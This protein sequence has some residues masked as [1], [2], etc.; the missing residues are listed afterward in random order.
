M[1]LDSNSKHDLTV[2]GLFQSSLIRT[3]RTAMIAVAAVVFLFSVINGR[4]NQTRAKAL[5]LN[6]VSSQ[7]KAA[8]M[9]QDILAVT[10]ELDRFI[11]AWDVS[12]PLSAEIEILQDGRL[13]ARAGRAGG[14]M[15]L[16]SE[17]TETIALPSGSKLTVQA[18]LSPWQYIK[19][20]ALLLLA[21]EF[22][23]L[24]IFGFMKWRIQRAIPRVVR[25]LT[26]IIQWLEQLALD[27][28]RSIDTAPAPAGSNIIELNVLQNSIR[29]FLNEI[30]S[31]ETNLAQL[32]I[33]RARLEVAEQVAHD[34]RSP[35]GTLT[36]LINSTDSIPESKKPQIQKSLGR[37]GEIIRSLRIPTAQRVSSGSLSG[38][39]PDVG[40]SSDIDLVTV[41]R[42][43]SSVVEEKRLQYSNRPELEFGLAIPRL[44]TSL[45]RIDSAAWSRCLSNLLDNAV[46]AISGAGKVN[47]SAEL[48][49]QFLQVQISDTGVGIGPDLLPNLGTR[50]ATFGK[51]GGSGLGLAFAKT[52]VEHWG[53]TLSIRSELGEG[54]DVVIRVPVSNPTSQAAPISLPAE[55]T[56]IIVDDDYLVHQCWRER[57]AD[58]A[59]SEN[60][61][62]TVHLHSPEELDEWLKRNGKN[63]DQRFF[64]MD[65]DFK[66]SPLNGLD[67]IAKYSL[68]DHSL[69]V[70][71]RCDDASVIERSTRLK[72]KR[73]QK[74]L[75]GSAQ[76][77]IS[78]RISK[79]SG[80]AI[81]HSSAMHSSNRPAGVLTGEA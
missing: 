75:I 52:A 41:G 17:I 3:L 23:L 80:H 7:S 9:R 65:F 10:R 4:E 45:A 79:A 22:V 18:V 74:D 16:A 40:A 73:L 70:S 71:G 49:D 55:S 12:Q 2:Q 36:L 77:Q 68:A 21:L 29:S 63:R 66:G 33:D 39:A 51:P 1:N 72:V 26:E 15:V 76:I 60:S 8:L 20:S 28:P 42:L 5:L 35:L 14:P 48:V 43:V 57:L 32:H 67:L 81:R 46:E 47:V 6:Q 62:K 30:R 54:T 78:K 53:G 25:P 58:L 11:A 38:A 34:L 69:L 37:I 13:V 64:L 59:L 61:V 50:G 56:W 19:Q 24:L 44:G 27:L 31:L